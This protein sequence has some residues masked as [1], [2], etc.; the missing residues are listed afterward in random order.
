MK[1]VPQ[2]LFALLVL[3]CGALVFSSCA[4][5]QPPAGEHTPTDLPILAQWSGDYPV[6]Q[7]DQLPEGQTTG[8]AGYMGTS[9]QFL[10]VWSVFKPGEKVPPVDFHANLVIFSRNIDFYNRINIMKVTLNDG[11]ADIIAMETRSARLIE[12]QVAMAMAVIPRAGLK[13]IRAGNERLE[14][15]SHE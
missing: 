8:Q 14:V 2:R 6:A 15:A 3:M 10:R 1:K 9:A 13:A 5:A 4:H 11:V 12:D 7:L